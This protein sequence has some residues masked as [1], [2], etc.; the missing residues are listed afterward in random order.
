MSQNLHSF[1]FTDKLNLE[2]GL[3]FVSW[4]QA[5][6]FFDNFALQ[7]GKHNPWITTDPTKHR[8]VHSQKTE[9]PWHIN[10]SF[11]K[12]SEIVPQFRK[13]TSSMLKDIKNM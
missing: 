9:C 7:K 11:P 3:T 2:E 8:N 4:K 10:L 12:S 1:D 13:L 5:K 6:L